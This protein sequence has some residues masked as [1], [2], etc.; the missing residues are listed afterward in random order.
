VT[1]R[2]EAGVAFTD[3][4]PAQRQNVMAIIGKS[5]HGDERRRF[6]RLQRRLFAEYRLGGFLARWKHAHTQDISLGGMLLNTEEPLCTGQEARVRV[7]LDDAVPKPLDADVVVIDSQPAK[8]KPGII[9]TRMRFGPLD[10]ATQARLVGYISKLVHATPLHAHAP[11]SA[12]KAEGAS[13]SEAR[14]AS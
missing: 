1:G 3:L 5:D 8:E 13:G 2:N 10:P 14:T 12:V 4:T 7:H 9:N 11:P 6:L